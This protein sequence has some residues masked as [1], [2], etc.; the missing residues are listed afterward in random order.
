MIGD[1]L[2]HLSNKLKVNN[3][4]GLQAFRFITKSSFQELFSNYFRINSEKFGIGSEF[5]V[6]QEHHQ[7][8]S[9]M[10]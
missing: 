9:T 5:F 4:K 3:S 6:Q 7:S 10:C 2:L 1:L 8:L